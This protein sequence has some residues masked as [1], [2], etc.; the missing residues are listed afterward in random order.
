M[1]MIVKPFRPLDVAL[2]HKTLTLGGSK[3]HLR[4]SYLPGTSATILILAPK[5][6]VAAVGEFSSIVGRCLNYVALAYTWI[7]TY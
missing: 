6:S 7:L 1:P 4:L 2:F 5:I 3:I